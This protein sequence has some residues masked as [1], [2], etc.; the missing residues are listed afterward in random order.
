MGVQRQIDLLR[1]GPPPTPP[2]LSP[3]AQGQAAG[4]AQDRRDRKQLKK[5]FHTQKR[6]SHVAARML[7]RGYSQAINEL[8][9]QGLDG[10]ELTQAIREFAAR[11]ADAAAAAQYHVNAER[12]DFQKADQALADDIGTART[13]LKATISQEKQQ[14]AE[15]V[16]A[17][18]NKL[19]V[20]NL[21][22]VQRANAKAKKAIKNANKKARAGGAGGLTPT[23]ARAQAEARQA[24]LIGIR[25]IIISNAPD[26]KGQTPVAVLRTN[27]AEFIRRAA[28]AIE[29]ASPTDV[30]WALSHLAQKIRAA[31]SGD[32]KALASIRR[33]GLGGFRAQAILGR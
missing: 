16:Q 11:Q 12:K 1:V 23:Q 31:Q 6:A 30:A 9:A 13:Q 2:Q 29:S 20:A 27:R 18:N 33:A 8:R 4:L 24:A 21:E 25:G 17:Y 15:D 14:Y 32:A 3:S 7:Q 10:P 19:S 5:Q 26:S 22:A 28:S